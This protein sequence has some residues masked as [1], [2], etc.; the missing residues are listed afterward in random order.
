[1]NPRS[2]RLTRPTDLGDLEALTDEEIAGLEA[3]NGLRQFDRTM[4]LIGEAVRTRS[5]RLRPS[6]LLELNRLAVEGLEGSAGQYRVANIE[7]TN[8]LHIPPPHG[9]VPRLVEEMCDYVNERVS[10]DAALELAA[11]V[12]WRLNWIHPYTNGNGRTSRAAS[13]F[14]LCACL[15]VEL[16][17]APT[18]PEMIAADKH[19]Y[20]R[21][22]DAA[23][24]AWRAGQVDV[25]AMSE[26]ILDHLKRQVMPSSE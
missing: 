13:Y 3:E 4:E 14:T 12:M 21:A 10:E 24:A 1:M 9:Q 15:G 18:V 20:Y 17:G 19:P 8:S 26:L 23:D 25:S 22:L 7:I 2:S 5:F 6:T 16:P 11:Y